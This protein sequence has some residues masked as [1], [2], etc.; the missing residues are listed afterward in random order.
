MKSPTNEIQGDPFP[1]NLNSDEIDLLDFSH[2]L[3][4]QKYIMLIFMMIG[5]ILGV[6]LALSLPRYYEVSMTVVPNEQQTSNKG[7]L[8]GIA[9]LA[10]I[11]G[12]AGQIDEKE[13][14]LLILQSR[15][16]ILNFID[17]HNIKNYLFPTDTSSDVEEVL[18]PANIYESFSELLVVTQEVTSND[19][20]VSLMWKDAELAK[21]WLTYLMADLNELMRERAKIKGEKSLAYLTNQLSQTRDADVRQSFI[22]MIKDETQ[23]MMLVDIRDE[24][25]F[26]TIDNPIIPAYP[27]KPNRK[28]IVILSVFGGFII[29]IFVALFREARKRTN[30]ASE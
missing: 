8:G 4:K 11:G 7:Q 17:A 9:A 26:E 28:L 30:R 14:G 21:D 12:T 18:L 25:L 13:I 24:Y 5:L 3:K 16:F 22:A 19:L 29:G 20:T 6:A 23:K 10:G 27:S 1:D 15:K 2:I